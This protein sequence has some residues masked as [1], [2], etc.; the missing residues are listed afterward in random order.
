MSYSKILFFGC[1]AILLLGSCSPKTLQLSLQPKANDAFTYRMT[2]NINNAVSVMGVDQ[3]TTMEQIMDYD[4]K[5]QKINSDGTVELNSTLKKMRMEQAAPMMSVVYDSEKP[6]DNNPADMMKSMD[7]LI[8]QKFNIKLNKTGEVVMVKGSDEMFEGLFEG[9]P[10]GEAM[11]EQMKSQF[12]ANNIASGLEYLTGFYP[13]ESIKVGDTWVKESTK[14]ITTSMVA[15]TTYTLKERKN[16]IA[17]ITFTSDLK[18]PPATEGVEMMGMTIKYDLKGTQTGTITV[19]EAT[20][21][22]KRTDIT[23]DIGGDMK[24]SGG[25]VGAT[26]MSATMKVG[27]T[28]IYERL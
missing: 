23:Q 26:E 24:M 8:G 18:S 15:T 2:Q 22:A 4:Y 6:E 5:V 10:N 13:K 3:E 14:Q 16:G 9:T 21:W 7:K 28:Y 25:P 20:G 17:T 12:G 19:D 1:L 27:G 11:S